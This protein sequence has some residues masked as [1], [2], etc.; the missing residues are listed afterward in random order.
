MHLSIRKIF[1]NL[2]MLLLLLGG[3]VTLLT[4][5][6]FHISQYSDRLGALKHQHLLIDKI[7]NTDM[8]DPAM[9]SI[10][11]NGALAEISLS[12]KLSGEEALLDFFI[13]SNEEQASLLRSLTLSS[14]T[15]QDNALIW[16]DS[17]PASLEFNRDRMMHARTA[18]LADISRMVDFQIQIIGKSISTAKITSLFV[19]LLGLFVYFFYS[20]RLRQIYRDIHRAASLD[21][22]GGKKEAYTREI[23]FIL[24]R[25]VRQPS[26]AV[27]GPN[28][29]HPLSGLNNER[30]L[31]AALNSKRGGKGG[32]LVYLCLFEIDGYDALRTTLSD[33]ER[34]SMFAKIG[35]IISLYEQPLDVVAH[36][37][38]DRIVCVLS[39]NTKQSA[40]ESCEHIVRSVEESVF[41]SSQGA[42]RITLSAG[43][44]LKVL[45]KNIEETMEDAVKLLRKAKENGGNRIAQLRD[46]VDA[47]R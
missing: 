28:L 37:G 12:V 9:A 23:D 15:F 36:T 10:L 17:S 13:N 27:T 31:I 18:Y 2:Q 30:G 22:N 24:K 43:F 46:E 32:N 25:L 3:G 40:L 4:L 7:L 39:R 11:I 33:E 44:L 16:S 41:S 6:L 5:Q 21:T 35:E 47:F 42:L 14:Q 20:H 8:S 26:Q 45:N 1:F 29:T 34:G 19:F 38:D